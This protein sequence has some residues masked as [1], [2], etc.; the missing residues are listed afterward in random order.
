MS[1]STGPAALEVRDLS[2]GTASR[3]LVEG[4]SFRVEPGRTLGLVGESG[5]GKSLTCM[6]VPDLLPRGVQRL[7]GTVTIGDT[8]V[9]SLSGRALER[10]RGTD[11]GVV[12]QESMSSLNPAFTIG[13]QLAAR[14]RRHH[15]LSKS[16]AEKRTVEALASVGI[17]RPDLRVRAYPFQLSGGMS[18]RAMIAMA[19]VGRPK[20]LLADEPTTALDVTVQAQVLELLKQLQSEL[21]MAVVFVSHDLGVIKEVADD[22]AVMYA[23][24]VVDAGP[25]DQILRAPGHPYTEGLLQA[26][27]P[28]GVD[29]G[30]LYVIPGAPPADPG[31]VSGCRFADRCPYATTVC[32]VEPGLRAIG[33]SG[34]SR[35]ARIDDLQLQGVVSDG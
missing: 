14:L 33:P 29:G 9:T 20:V 11:I 18:Q 26:S 17:P 12:F 25:A 6:A 27:Q 30:P 8:E 31:A 19:V 34:H 35:C 2:I 1:A 32:R 21:D 15:G 5:S 23:G 3:R 13:D 4:V 16:D 22:I 24:Q 10:V 7:S 28:R